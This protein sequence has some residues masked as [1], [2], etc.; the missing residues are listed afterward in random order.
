MNTNTKNYAA[1]KALTKVETPATCGELIEEIPE[2]KRPAAEGDGADPADNLT[3][4]MAKLYDDHLVD[5]RKRDAKW[6]PMEY[7]LAADGRQALR[8]H[9]DLDDPGPGSPDVTSTDGSDRG[10][11]DDVLLPRD[12]DAR[13][14]AVQAL[15][16]RI[17]ELQDQLQEAQEED[18]SGVGEFKPYIEKLA[19]L[20]DDGYGLHAGSIDVDYGGNV[21]EV[22]VKAKPKRK[23]R[24]KGPKQDESER[25][26]GAGEGDTS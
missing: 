10:H 22:S 19:E 2:D 18:L 6:R 3:S 8:E 21:V 11:G 15:H 25:K 9:D 23:V 1:L 20:A 4:I 13:S 12:E 24:G 17:N 7:W 14:E 5:R 26:T 16:D